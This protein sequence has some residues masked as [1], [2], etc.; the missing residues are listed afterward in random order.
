MTVLSVAKRLQC[1]TD[2]GSTLSSTDGS[3]YHKKYIQI[4]N[5]VVKHKPEF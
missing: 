3:T 2:D 1:S 5:A 4:V